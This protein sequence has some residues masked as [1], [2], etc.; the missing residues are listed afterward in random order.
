M[1]GAKPD[2]GNHTAESLHQVCIAEP[3]RAPVR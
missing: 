3:N 2:E 1:P